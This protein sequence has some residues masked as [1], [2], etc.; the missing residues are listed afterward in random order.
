MALLKTGSTGNMEEGPLLI[1]SWVNW[2]SFRP[3]PPWFKGTFSPG[4][5]ICRRDLKWSMS[6]AKDVNWEPSSWFSGDWCPSLAVGWLETVLAGEPLL[7]AAREGEC[8]ILESCL[9]SCLTEEAEAFLEV[10]PDSVD[11]STQTGEGE[12]FLCFPC[13]DFLGGDSEGSRLLRCF[14]GGL[15]LSVAPPSVW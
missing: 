7:A 15:T 4:S 8:T 5:G 14:G 13:F 12:A 11:L 3:I 9:E 10:L 6:V 1:L 2:S